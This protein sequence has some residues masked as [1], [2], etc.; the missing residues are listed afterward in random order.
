MFILFFTTSCKGDGNLTSL[1]EITD[2][3]QEVAS[4]KPNDFKDYSYQ[5]IGPEV[6]DKIPEGYISTKD[7]RDKYGDLISIGFFESQVYLFDLDDRTLK[8]RSMSD[9]VFLVQFENDL[10]IREAEI[11][12]LLPLAE[13]VLEE[14]NKIYYIG[15]SIDTHASG[16]KPATL[17]VDDVSYA[18]NYEG[19]DLQ[20][21]EW[22]CIVKISIEANSGEAFSDLDQV[23]NAAWRYFEHAEDADGQVYM[24]VIKLTDDREYTGIAEVDLNEI[25]LKLPKEVK[26]KYLYLRSSSI[27][28]FL[29]K[30]DVGE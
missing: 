21:D 18:E 25:V 22:V 10:Y 30:V 24:D 9:S 2:F 20:N 12:T 15:D 4:A 1:N 29:R 27:L 6:V 17:T 8:Q 7:A 14:R 26:I 28:V 11:T 13:K 23:R 5:G 16:G 3:P 19:V